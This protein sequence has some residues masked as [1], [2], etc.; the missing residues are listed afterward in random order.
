MYLR[1]SA[2]YTGSYVVGR[3]VV[4]GTGWPYNPWF[5]NVFIPRPVTLGFGATF[6]TGWGCWGF[7]LAPVGARRALLLV[8]QRLVGLRQ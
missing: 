3:A 4:F 5:G 2:G 8:E 1:L 6:S 7:E